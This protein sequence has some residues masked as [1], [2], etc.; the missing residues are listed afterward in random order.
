MPQTEKMI[1]KMIEKIVSALT[2]TG[3]GVII[4][5]DVTPGSKK[6]TVPSGYNEWRNRIEVK[7]TKP[8]VDGKANKELIDSLS[9]IL[10]IPKKNLIIISGS[11]NSKKSVMVLHTTKD[12]IARILA[13]RIVA[14]TGPSTQDTLARYQ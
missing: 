13:E 6:K 10:S 3:D 11:T 4:E 7:L 1:E 9:D 8:P 14:T 5:I 2:E 12:E